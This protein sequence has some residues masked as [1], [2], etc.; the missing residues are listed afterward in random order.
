[1]RQGEVVVARI[2]EADIVLRPATMWIEEVP[3]DRE[4]HRAPYGSTV[5]QSGTGQRRPA[6]V[7]VTLE[8]HAVS[9]AQAAAAVRGVVEALRG[10]ASLSVPGLGVSTA[11]VTE[12]VV[13]P[14]AAGYRADVRLLTS[15]AE[16]F[17]PTGV[18]FDGA[19]VFFGG[20]PVV[21]SGGGP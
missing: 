6:E 17:T 18:V 7:L 21:W 20:E 19:A 10:P 5:F 15:S 4:L 1:M 16:F 3:Y 13:S 12:V 2:G 9:I 14:V 11:G 8:V